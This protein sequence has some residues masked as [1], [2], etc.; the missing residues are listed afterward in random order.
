MI[1][2]K[3]QYVLLEIEALILR[4]QYKELFTSNIDITTYPNTNFRRKT[5]F[6]FMYKQVDKLNK[7][8]DIQY[9]RYYQLDLKRSKQNLLKLVIV[10]LFTELIIQFRYRPKTISIL[11]SYQIQI[12]ATLRLIYA[13]QALKRYTILLS[14]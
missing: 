14:I 6:S 2:N 7:F 13:Y 11:P 5:L 4:L 8:L 10:I 12:I 3:Q 9:T 1:L